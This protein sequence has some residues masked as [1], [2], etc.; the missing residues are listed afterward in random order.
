MMAHTPTSPEEEEA[1]SNYGTETTA[2]DANGSLTTETTT[3]QRK[4]SLVGNLKK[5][6]R[7][8]HTVSEEVSDDGSR[9]RMRAEG[10]H[11]AKKQLESINYDISSCEEQ[12]KLIQGSRCQRRSDESWPKPSLSFK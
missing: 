3:R 2:T 10:M 11:G 12:L 4:R 5:K 9:S 8:T 7:P 6:R 1:A